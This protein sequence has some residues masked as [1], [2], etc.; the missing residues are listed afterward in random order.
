MTVTNGRTNGYTNGHTNGY[1]NGH[2]K[3]LPSIQPEYDVV[4]VGGGP[5]GLLMAYQL[6]RFGL[7]SAVFE[8]YE[9]ET[10]DAFG[11]AIAFFPR[12]ME[13]LD[14]LELS[15]PMLQTGFPCRSSVTYKDGKQV[16][17]GRVWTF[18]E[19][20][21][22]SAFDFTLVLRQ[23]YTEGILREK[24][25]DNDIPLFQGIEC[26]DFTVDAAAAPIDDAVTSTMLNR[27][28]KEQ[29]TV[30]SKYIIGADGGRSFVRR[31]A[32]IPFEG[33]LTE[34][35][36]IRIDGVVETDM[37]IT[38]SYGA[39]ES[40]THGNVLWAPLDNGATR[41]GYAYTPEIAAKYPSGVTQEVAEKEA[42]EA[43]K[44]FQLTFKKTD[45]WTLYAIAQRMAKSFSA[46]GDRVFICGDAAH[47]HSSG[48]AQGLNTGIHDAVN[49]GW[50][51]ALRA[52]G[53]LRPEALH[54]YSH[55]RKTV[56]EQLIRYDR[57]IATLMSHKWPAWYEGDRAA[58]P[59]LILG[60]IF[61][62]ATS[63]NTG[64]G[65][66]YPENLLNKPNALPSLTVAPG[67]RPHDVTLRTPGTH[68]VVRLQQATRN[69]ACFHV[70][71]FTGDASA[72]AGTPKPA[73]VALADVLA[74]APA[75]SA[76]PAIRF[77]TVSIAESGSPYE[78]LGGVRPFGTMYYDPAGAAHGALGIPVSEGGIMVLRPDGLLGSGGPI[79]GAFVQEYFDNI[80]VK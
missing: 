66:A 73:V 14:Q 72:V 44:P 21:S 76:S 49:L 5:V 41:I 47:T 63:F 16:I 55:E 28:T 35:K 80:L 27:K 12:T 13:Q 8:Q 67:S 25:D 26:I 1:S 64:L 48:A 79:S 23:M 58:D 65:I 70:V 43:M 56:V 45:W 61:E 40:K 32:G 17:P 22:G 57:D 4:I 7:S 75:L 34:D 29:Y 68:Q 52:R 54:T 39:I 78:S 42:A 51:L 15:E 9:K 59:Y 37:P 11:R 33:D 77:L 53:L 62:K 36:W 71:V 50:K 24:L 60:D 30:K 3:P 6:K 74:A 38:R 18:M 69:R 19:N 20:M 10:Q 46:L 2:T 31:H